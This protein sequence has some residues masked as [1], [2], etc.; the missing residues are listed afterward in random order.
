[1]ALRSYVKVQ[2]AMSRRNIRRVM[3]REIMASLLCGNRSSSLLKRRDW[4]SNAR[5]RSMWQ[6]QYCYPDIVW[7]VFQMS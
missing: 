4:L 3:Q 5:V 2:A 1:M 6:P 7:V